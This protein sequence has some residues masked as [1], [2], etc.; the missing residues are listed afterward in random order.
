MKLSNNSMIE[1]KENFRR[2]R[3]KS[4]ATMGGNS[5]HSTI[6][7]LGNHYEQHSR[8][9]KLSSLERYKNQG[10]DVHLPSIHIKDNSPNR[11]LK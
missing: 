5:K 3:N 8:K 6:N 2:K 1:S 7:I 10:E 9:P 4:I 11:E